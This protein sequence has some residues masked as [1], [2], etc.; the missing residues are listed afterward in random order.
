MASVE[1]LLPDEAKA[2]EVFQ[3]VA[4]EFAYIAS[5]L[6]PEALAQT[7][8]EGA[9][10]SE[11]PAVLNDA[12]PAADPDPAPRPEDEVAEVPPAV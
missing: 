1:L 6:D 9:V 12:P 4:S 2:A 11:D 7:L 8:T 10:L 3:R 5:K